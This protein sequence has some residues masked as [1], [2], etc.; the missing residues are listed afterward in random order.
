MELDTLLQNSEPMGTNSNNDSLQSTS[1]SGQNTLPSTTSTVNTT[2][3]YTCNTLPNVVVPQPTPNP[4][5]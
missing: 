3:H 5:V 2:P 1:T 4:H